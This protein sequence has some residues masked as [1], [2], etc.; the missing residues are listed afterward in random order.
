[1]IIYESEA[2]AI[3]AAGYNTAYAKS[4]A[5]FNPKPGFKIVDQLVD[6]S[7]EACPASC[8]DIGCGQGALLDHIYSCS[9]KVGGD[10]IKPERFL[11]VD[12]S[13]VAIDQCEN[14][15]PSLAWVVDSFQG[16]AE[17][18]DPASRFPDGVDLIVNKAGLTK[19]GSEDEF[20]NIF[21][22]IR[23]LLS[24]SGHFL[25]TCSKPFYRKWLSANATDW[26]R[27]PIQIAFD[28]FGEPQY[29]TDETRYILLF[30]KRTPDL[31][32]A[33]PAAVEFEFE[34]GSKSRIDTYFDLDIRRRVELATGLPH[35][36]GSTRLN[37]VTLLSDMNF[38]ANP[39][40]RVSSS[41]AIPQIRGKGLKVH[42][43][44]RPLNSS[45]SLILRANEFCGVKC[46]HV[47]LGGSLND[48]LVSSDTGQPH[49]DPDEFEARLDWFFS[50]LKRH[51]SAHVTFL[52][53]FPIG[54]RHHP[55]SGDLYSESA[56]QPFKETLR[57][58]T[59]AHG[60][61]FADV[62]PQLTSKLRWFGVGGPLWQRASMLKRLTKAISTS[63]AEVRA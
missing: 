25:F 20:E 11:G 5:H 54:E 22:S 38:A 10:R 57:N 24:D 55:T 14:A 28:I 52:T 46:S 33:Y 34:D 26:R 13:K 50:F 41:Y 59:K 56:A 48:W 9:R 40:I 44:R 23:N 53:A 29:L 31:K 3:D 49:V 15:N 39:D 35:P 7:A 1:M 61:Q 58:L 12:I 27:E 37:K 32:D 30:S 45:K 19:V 43:L 8:I 6:F 51:Q 36:R 4:E 60:V 2:N 62:T 63:L 17:A 47:L 42:R 21:L 16:Y 18:A